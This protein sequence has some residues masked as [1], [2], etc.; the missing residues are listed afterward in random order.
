VTNQYG[1][2][3]FDPLNI[4]G[5]ITNKQGYV[6]GY[7]ILE[8][9]P[10][11]N[12][13]L[14]MSGLF[15]SRIFPAEFVLFLGNRTRPEQH[16]FVPQTS[17]ALDLFQRTRD[18][19]MATVTAAIT[20]A[21]LPSTIETTSPPMGEEEYESE[22]SEV[23]AMDVVRLEQATTTVMPAGWG[24]KNQRPE[25]PPTNYEM[26][27]KRMINGQARAFKMPM[28]I[29]SG[30]SEGYNYASGRLDH[31]SFWRTIKTARGD[32]GMQEL[33]KLLFHFFIELSALPKY[34]SLTKA[35]LPKNTL[36][37]VPMPVHT[38]MFPGLPHVDP[39][40]EA[41]AFAV[42]L[43]KDGITLETWFGEQGKDWRTELNQTK[44]EKEYM[45]E[46]GITKEEVINEQ[47][48]TK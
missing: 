13:Y 32:L 23:E 27:D 45:E 44:V 43:E 28:N 5:V 16:R 21:S 7:E 12:I 39:K 2:K 41:D 22:A 36:R 4:D 33:N 47:T 24:L 38:F 30:N 14:G 15:K 40:K 46:L 1:N 26:F 25:F 31:Q 11:E 19:M 29:A 6:T 37:K 34:K 9:H 18:Y 42:L 3:V 17:S 10:G 35:L 20:Q 8:E 48:Q